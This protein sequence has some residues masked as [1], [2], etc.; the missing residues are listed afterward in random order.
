[1]VFKLIDGAQR[2]WRRLDGHA[3]LPELVQGM[4]FSNGLEV[5]EKQS[6]LQ[7]QTAAA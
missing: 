4:K 7:P 3:Q 6:A 1:M 2:I 5:A